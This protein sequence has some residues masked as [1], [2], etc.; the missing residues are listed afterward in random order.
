MNTDYSLDTNYPENTTREEKNDHKLKT[1]YSLDTNSPENTTRQEKRDENVYES[2]TET[3]SNT[4]MSI[5]KDDFSNETHPVDH[6]VAAIEGNDVTDEVIMEELTNSTKYSLIETDLTNT[7]ID[8]KM[9]LQSTKEPIKEGKD[10]IN[11]EESD[12][13]NQEKN[14]EFSDKVK[15]VSDVGSI[16]DP[17]ILNSG[18]TQVNVANEAGDTGVNKSIIQ[19]LTI[20]EVNNDSEMGGLSE[21]IIEEPT[22]V[23]INNETK[24]AGNSEP[25]IQELTIMEMNN[26]TEPIIHEPTVVEMN[27]ESEIAGLSEPIIQE[28][29][30]VKINDE[31]EMAYVFG[32][33][34]LW[35]SIDE[36]NIEILNEVKDEHFEKTVNDVQI[37]TRDILNTE[38]DNETEMADIFGSN[39]LWQTSNKENIEI[40]NEVKKE[41]IEK[42]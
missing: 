34:S 33:T 11:T 28:P 19:G 39:S 38:I 40:L 37:L 30:F 23:E 26:A 41:N 24:M 35:Q 16:S 2:V 7:E 27:N 15:M 12:I 21:P 31:T 29:T 17:N 14:V 32:P 13:A 10:M 6:F 5:Y 22:V 25:I 1:D 8:N 4:L 20:M 36:G 42:Q 3:Y 18:E 9:E